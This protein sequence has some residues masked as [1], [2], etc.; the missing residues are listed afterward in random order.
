MV[1]MPKLR[2]AAV[3]RWG[4]AMAWMA[5]IFVLSAQSSLPEL[6][7]GLPKLEEVAGHASAYAVLAA[8]L[9]SALHRSGARRPASWA[10]IFAMLYGF[11]D[12]FHQSYVPGRAAAVDDLVVD[13]IGAALTLLF[14]GWLRSRRRAV[15]GLDD[16]LPWQPGR[17]NR[18]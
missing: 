13:L 2:P 5:V 7:P 9:W 11:S 12:E 17:G 6:T 10:L 15:Q 3:L 1:K 14:I 4:A 8:L 18:D 16:Y